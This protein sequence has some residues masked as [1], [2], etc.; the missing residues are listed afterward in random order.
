MGSE[1]YLLFVFD[2]LLTQ[3]LKVIPN[4]RS[5]DDCQR[6]LRLFRQF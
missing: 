2:K 6:N 4:W 1:A 5:N 3:T